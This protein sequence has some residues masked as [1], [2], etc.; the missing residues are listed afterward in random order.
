MFP[1]NIY[2]GEKKPAKVSAPGRLRLD[3][4][5]CGFPTVSVRLMYAGGR[6]VCPENKKAL[7][8]EWFSTFC[9][10]GRK[11]TFCGRGGEKYTPPS[12]SPQNIF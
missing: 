7:L 9:G 8:A 2:F 6:E 10:R 5:H 12:S 3:A 11:K 4:R 1:S